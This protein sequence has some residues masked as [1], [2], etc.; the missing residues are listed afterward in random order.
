[1]M[2][3]TEQSADGPGFTAVTPKCP[4]FPKNVPVAHRSHLYVLAS[5]S[6]L[7]GMVTQTAAPAQA[8]FPNRVSSARAHQNRGPP[9]FTSLV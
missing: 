2:Q 8:E 7:G 6:L 1:M 4:L 3:M 9:Q 5:M